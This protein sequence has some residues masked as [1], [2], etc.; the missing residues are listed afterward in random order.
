MPCI[1]NNT[2]QTSLNAP[3]SYHDGLQN[4]H[5]QQIEPQTV[6]IDQ[7]NQHLGNTFNTSFGTVTTPPTIKDEKLPKKN[8]KRFLCCYC[9]WSGNDN[10]GLKRH[11]N[12][13]LK[14]YVSR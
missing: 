2:Q 1:S 13:H 10:W 5:Q 3:I 14:P 7:T 8:D 12:T 4:Q 11:L 9:S 6:S